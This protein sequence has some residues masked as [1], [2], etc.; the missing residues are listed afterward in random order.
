MNS[1]VRDD[2]LLV[3]LHERRQSLPVEA[4]LDL[5]L[6]SGKLLFANGQTTE[7]MVFALRELAAAYG[8]QAT[9]FAVWGELTI[10]LENGARSYSETIAVEPFGVDMSKISATMSAI[11]QVWKERWVSPQRDSR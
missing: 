6:Q 4:T 9:I 3:S 2:H 1:D 8:V 7:R 11:H 10:R 5:L